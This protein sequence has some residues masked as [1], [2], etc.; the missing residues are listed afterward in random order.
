MFKG[1]IMFFS[2]LKDDLKKSTTLENHPEE[3]PEAT[4]ENLSS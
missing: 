1:R 4:I 2:Y 3:I